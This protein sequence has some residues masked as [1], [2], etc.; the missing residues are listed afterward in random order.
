MIFYSFKFVVCF[1]IVQSSLGPVLATVFCVLEKK[2][3]FCCL[4]VESS[5]I[6]RVLHVFCNSS[7]YEMILNG[8][9]FLSLVSRC[10]L[11]RYRNT[12]DLCL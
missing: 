10:L 4:K 3:V 9:P 2:Y 7:Q 12:I 8:L 5:I 1:L 11:L 6:I